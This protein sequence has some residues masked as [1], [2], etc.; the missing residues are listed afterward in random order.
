[1]ATLATGQRT[2]AAIHRAH[3][4]LPSV[5][6]TA[7]GIWLCGGVMWMGAWSV[8]FAVNAAICGSVIAIAGAVRAFGVTPPAW[9]G[10]L[11]FVLGLWC[12]F[13]PWW[14]GFAAA[15]G[16]TWTT[17]AAGALLVVTSIWSLTSTPSRPRR[18]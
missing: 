2:Q 13:A 7:I 10:W 16:P 17:A 4:R 15:R 14:L 9:A 3:G 18:A 5:I 6:S 12:V 11:N 1:M 8:A